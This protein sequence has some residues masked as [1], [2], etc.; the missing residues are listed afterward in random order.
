MKRKRIKNSSVEDIKRGKIKGDY[1][2]KE[3]LNFDTKNN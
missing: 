3:I 2:K 1:I